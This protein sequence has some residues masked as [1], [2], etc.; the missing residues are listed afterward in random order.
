[1]MESAYSKQNLQSVGS[2][3]LSDVWLPDF[4]SHTIFQIAFATKLRLSLGFMM[5]L[6]LFAFLT[7]SV[8]LPF[9]EERFLAFKTNAAEISLD[10]VLDNKFFQTGFDKINRAIIV[11]T[12]LLIV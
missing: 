10:R 2:W 12:Q 9:R 11:Q 4:T 3:Y 8:A 1:M 6:R 5:S 7:T